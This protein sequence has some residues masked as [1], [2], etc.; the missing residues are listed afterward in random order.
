MV[1]AGPFLEWLQMR[2]LRM[3]T[4]R[5]VVTELGIDSREVFRICAEPSL[6]RAELFSTA[7]QKFRFAM[8]V[9]LR[10]FVESHWEV[11]GDGQVGSALA[12][13]LCSML[14]AVSRELSSC[15][16]KLG[17]LLSSDF[18]S[19]SGSLT[20]DAAYIGERIADDCGFHAQER[21]PL[22]QDGV[23]HDP[24][25]IL[26]GGC[27]E[28]AASDDLTCD[29]T[30]PGSGGVVQLKVESD[31][32][33]E[34]TYGEVTADNVSLFQGLPLGH[35][36]AMSAAGAALGSH[37]ILTQACDVIY[38]TL[39]GQLKGTREFS[40][41]S[42]SQS[43]HH[44]AT[45]MQ[46]MERHPQGFHHR[47]HKCTYCPYTCNFKRRLYEHLRVHTGERPFKCSVCEKGFARSTE[48]RMHAR[49][50][51][52]EK[53]FT[54][55]VCGKAFAQL[56]HVQSHLRVHTR[57]RPFKCPVCDETFVWSNELRRHTRLH[58]GDCRRNNAGTYRGL[59]V[60]V[61]KEHSEENSQ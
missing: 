45:L 29:V 51:T 43:F 32:L 19:D 38:P 41:S 35:P 48:L 13:V 2:G 31:T 6:I 42:C 54:C 16:Q 39:G 23:S 59:R 40:C 4:A 30:P 7:K 17:L 18:E 11:R 50:H 26:S 20:E 27:V 57:E 44:E 49:V 22:S 21:G 28:D 47:K 52:G 12:D 34:C 56:H 1:E 5:A 3:E 24:R 36:Q 10:H 9:E 46:H 15:V 25:G 61:K 60:P 33:A 8:Y 58:N 55:P 14:S 53:P 37:G